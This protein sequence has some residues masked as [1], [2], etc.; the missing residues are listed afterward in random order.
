[1]E[2]KNRWLVKNSDGLVQGPYTTEE[3]L[4]KIK[5]EEFSGK[6]FISLYPD[7]KWMPITHTPSF[8]DSLFSALLASSNEEEIKKYIEEEKKSEVRD[9]IEA[10]KEKQTEAEEEKEESDYSITKTLDENQVSLTREFTRKNLKKEEKEEKE[11][12][13]GKEEES[14]EEEE[15][16]TQSQEAEEKKIDSQERGEEKTEYE[17]FNLKDLNQKRSSS[18]SSL[19]IKSESKLDLRLF[20]LLILILKKRVIW[21]LS[22]KTPV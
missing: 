13:E 11:G 2:K 3:I 22:L 18:S 9:N 4:E 17:V 12:K 7:G 6:E 19:E 8:Y 15:T 10:E 14:F 16:K 21:R 20:L 5:K 1:M